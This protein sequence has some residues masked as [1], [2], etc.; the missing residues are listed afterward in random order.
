MD[1]VVFVMSTCPIIVP[2]YDLLCFHTNL[3]ISG[4]RMFIEPNST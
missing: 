2:E 4:V 3:D 1:V